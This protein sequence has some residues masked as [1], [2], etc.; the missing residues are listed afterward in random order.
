MWLF[1]CQLLPLPQCLWA[2]QDETSAPRNPQHL[3]FHPRSLGERQTD[4]Q[5]WV[6]LDTIIFTQYV[7]NWQSLYVNRQEEASHL[8]CIQQYSPVILTRPTMRSPLLCMVPMRD[9]CPLPCVTNLTPPNAWW[10]S[11]L[12]LDPWPPSLPRSR[13]VRA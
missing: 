12:T 11:T 5:T 8:F 6:I 7:K 1:S 2:L 13:A 4:F 3:Q 10:S 9:M